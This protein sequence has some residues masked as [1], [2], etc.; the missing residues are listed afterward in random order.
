MSFDTTVSLPEQTV[1][2]WKEEEVR[3]QVQESGL[4][5]RQNW[6]HIWVSPPTTSVPWHPRVSL[7]PPS[8]DQDSDGTG[9]I[10]EL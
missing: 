10:L 6:I 1:E 4:Q 7:L 5:V 3:C 9:F 2:Y 8:V